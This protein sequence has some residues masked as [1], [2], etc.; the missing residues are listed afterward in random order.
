MA[1]QKRL[2]LKMCV[3]LVILSAACMPMVAFGAASP[4]TKEGLDVEAAVEKTE[5]ES[6]E[7][8][9]DCASCHEKEDA[10]FENGRCLMSKHAGVA[11]TICHNEGSVLD[12]VHASVV[13]TK[14]PK[15]LS[16]ST[17]S[18][19]VCL[20]CHGTMESLEKATQDCIL[21]T[22]RNGTTINP[23]ALP[24]NNEH[25]TNIGCTTCHAMHS[26]R[27]AKKLAPALCKS[28]H[29]ENVYECG[30]CHGL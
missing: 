19:E 1:G 4:D 30:T 7:T 5:L 11:C 6:W 12:N 27:A 17:I 22:D 29:H 28:C 10:S 18:N 8:D 25:E 14:T 24:A 2:C 20:S 3:V 15:N 16:K 13:D 9:L 21:L 26:N 23:H